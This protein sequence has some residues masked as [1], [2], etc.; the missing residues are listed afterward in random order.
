[1]TPLRSLLIAITAAIVAFAA[2][3]LGRDETRHTPFLVGTL[4]GGLALW[5]CIVA[6]SCCGLWGD[7]IDRPDAGAPRRYPTCGDCWDDLGTGDGRCLM[8]PALPIPDSPLS[9]YRTCGECQALHTTARCYPAHVG[10]Y[11][12]ETP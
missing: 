11:P 2:A 8:L 1:M 12:G 10:P 9:D 5:A 4:L 3:R 7:P 6:P